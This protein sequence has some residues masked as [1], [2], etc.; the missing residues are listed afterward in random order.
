MPRSERLYLGEVKQAIG[1][2]QELVADRADLDSDVVQAATF[3]HL[4]VIG[5]AV[6]NLPV[7]V[8][9]R[10]PSIDWSAVV[11]MRN[12]LVHAYFGID[13]ERV[14]RT[15]AFELPLLEAAVD[16]LLDNTS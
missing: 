16:R 11:G 3:W 1:R 2:I 10:E 9:N 14:W 15:V 12:V 4:T 5:E 6:R 7:Q 8:K 13:L